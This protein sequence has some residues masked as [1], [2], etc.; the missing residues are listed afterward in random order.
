MLT[1]VQTTAPLGVTSICA[2]RNELT[3]PTLGKETSVS[4]P[5]SLR[6]N[7]MKSREGI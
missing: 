1:D 4:I 2:M 6:R 7:L 5:L 3:L